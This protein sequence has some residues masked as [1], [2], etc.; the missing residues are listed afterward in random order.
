MLFVLPQWPGTNVHTHSQST[1][2]KENH[3]V[4]TYPVPKLPFW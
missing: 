4:I 2:P 3:D 1:L